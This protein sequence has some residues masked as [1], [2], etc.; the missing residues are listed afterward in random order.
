MLSNVKGFQ[1]TGLTL[2]IPKLFLEICENKTAIP[3]MKVAV[4]EEG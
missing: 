4:N 2:L 3:V 1:K